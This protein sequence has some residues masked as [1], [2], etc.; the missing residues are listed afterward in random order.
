MKETQNLLFITYFLKRNKDELEVSFKGCM[1]IECLDYELP[2][3][4]KGMI[5]IEGERI[6]VIDP[7]VYFKGQQSI[8]GNLAC[9]LVTQC[10]Y[11]NQNCRVGVIIED[12]DD[13]MNLVV[14]NNK[15]TA[16]NPLTFNMNFIINALKKGPAE[17]FLTNTQKLYYMHEQRESDNRCSLAKYHGYNTKTNDTEMDEFEIFD[18]NEFLVTI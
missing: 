16:F 10:A 6:Q 17:Q 5:K 13:I 18:I 7:K 3:Y 1:E 2:S 11:M 4:I 15:N 8:P 12:I 14:C 9:I